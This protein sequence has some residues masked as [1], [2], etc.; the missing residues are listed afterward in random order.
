MQRQEGKADKVR[1]ELEQAAELKEA[2]E[3]AAADE[4]DKGPAIAL[5]KT[6]KLVFFRRYNTYQALLEVYPSDSL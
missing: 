6:T 4:A 5:A 3:A 1:R 2:A